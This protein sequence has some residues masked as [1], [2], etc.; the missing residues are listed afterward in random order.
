MHSCE[1]PS[2][3]FPRAQGKRHAAKEKQALTRLLMMVGTW[4]WQCRS[5][6]GV[7]TTHHSLRSAGNTTDSGLGVDMGEKR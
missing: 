1:L 7:S 5:L 3:E 2:Q 6:K 4:A